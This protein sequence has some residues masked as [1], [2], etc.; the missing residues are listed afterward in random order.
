MR[1]RHFSGE[2]LPCKQRIHDCMTLSD[3]CLLFLTSKTHKEKF[4]KLVFA[5]SCLVLFDESRPVNW[6]IGF[7]PGACHKLCLSACL[8][9]CL[10]RN[11]TNPKQ[12]LF[13]IPFPTERE[14]YLQLSNN[15]PATYNSCILVNAP[16]VS[17]G[18]WSVCKCVLSHR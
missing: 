18:V 16:L 17:G 3:F 10:R 14:V 13:P 11:P 1:I 7:L 5:P 9:V 15:Y 2:K 12:Y 8:S 6:M 4:Q